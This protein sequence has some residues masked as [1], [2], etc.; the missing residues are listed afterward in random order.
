[1]SSTYGDLISERLIAM[2]AILAAGHIPAAME[3]FSPGDETAW[4]KIRRWIDESDCFMLMLG[5]RYGSIEPKSRKSYVQLEYE[6][7]LKK[8]KPFFSLVITPEGLDARVRKYG[9]KID[10]RDNQES[11]KKFLSKVKEPH[12]A[13]WTEPKDITPVVILKLSQ[14]SQR[15]DL[16]GWV[17]GDEAANPEVTNELAHLSI[18]NREL[19]EKLEAEQE[20]FGGL[21][22][23]GLVSLLCKDKLDFSTV[24]RVTGPF[25]AVLP[26][27]GLTFTYND[28]R[29]LS[30]MLRHAGH[31]FDYFMDYLANEEIYVFALADKARL[32][33]DTAYYLMNKLVLFGLVTKKFEEV[34]NDIPY[35]IFSIS[36]MGRI[37]RNRLLSI[38]DRETRQN[39]LWSPQQE[40]RAV[41]LLPVERSGP[42]RGR[43]R[44]SP[45]G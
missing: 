4:E 30:H 26:M 17:R 20:S 22:F 29:A 18:E 34:K 13:F 36:D 40:G 42:A 14:W 7:A 21:D 9:L 38:G 12:C 8:K 25:E 45:P 27:C 16:M 10:E 39:L 32:F 44:G 24:D 35:F 2:E 19:R 41:P 15:D 33:K 1:M 6:Y 37:F 5:G 31:V 28:T 23:N 43:R 3:Q 11:Y